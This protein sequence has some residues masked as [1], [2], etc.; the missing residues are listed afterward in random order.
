M[1][2]QF[3]SE[4]VLT[5]ENEERKLD[6]IS[7]SLCEIIMIKSFKRGETAR[8]EIL[9]SYLRQ[10]NSNFINKLEYQNNTRI[11]YELTLISFIENSVKQTKKGKIYSVFTLSKGKYIR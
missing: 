4:T 9:P 8:I 3:G 5:L 2:V 7:F 10:F 1:K 6:E 11:C